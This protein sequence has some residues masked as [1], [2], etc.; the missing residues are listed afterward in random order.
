[1]HR[2]YDQ[3]LVINYNGKDLKKEYTHTHTHT[4]ITKLLSCTPEMNTITYPTIMCDG[5]ERK[6]FQEGGDICI[7]VIDSLGCTAQTNTTL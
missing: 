6:E 1:M 2:N 3:Y 5:W 4:C 7:S